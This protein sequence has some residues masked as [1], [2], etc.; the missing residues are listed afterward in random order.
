M[1]ETL[2]KEIVE[3]WSDTVNA[4]INERDQAADYLYRRLLRPNLS[5]D[6]SF[7]AISSTNSR[8]TADI[9]VM[10]SD[11]PLKSRGSMEKYTGKI[12]KIGIQRYLKESDLTA[13]DT[14]VNRN[15][16]ESII[17][18]KVFDDLINCIVGTKEKVELMTH[19]MLAT[20]LVEIPS[21]ENTGRS[22]RVD[23]GVPEDN[24]LTV[25][26]A[27]SDSAADIAGDIER[28]YNTATDKGLSIGLMRMNRVTFNQVR[29]N[30]SIL[31][32]YNGF[33]EVSADTAVT[34]NLDKL[35]DLFS[36]EY[37]FTIEIVDRTFDVEKDG[38]VKTV[39]GFTDGAVSFWPNNGPVGDLTYAHLA[40]LTRPVAK[41]T[42]S[43]PEEWMLA[44][45]WSDGNPL[46]EFSEASGLVIPVLQNVDQVFFMDA[47][48]P[49]V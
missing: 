31:A 23:Y 49:E 47:V 22:I 32:L 48:N 9:V 6:H 41:K 46:R 37:G 42:Y 3:R 45:K 28:A 4:T 8:V 43:Q 24:R 26:T 29:K 27:W 44:A 10:D 34:L 35:N 1:E 36:S 7:S 19:Q 33:R 17:A 38:V 13:I 2:F 39:R 14:L 5:V 30:S 21:N 16:A 40:E 12:P 20:G 11:L 25:Q 15:T 18:R